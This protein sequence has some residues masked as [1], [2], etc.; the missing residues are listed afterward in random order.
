MSAIN[1]DYNLIA[2]GN[3][4]HEEDHDFFLTKTSTLTPRIPKVPRSESPH[5]S[6]K[7]NYTL[8]VIVLGSVAFVCV[9]AIVI[10]LVL[11]KKKKT[12]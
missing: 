4:D 7:I 12:R 10:A 3:E 2:H 1:F 8:L 11:K 5:S 6:V 9:S